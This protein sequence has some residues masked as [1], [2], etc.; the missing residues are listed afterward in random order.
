MRPADDFIFWGS[1]GH[2]KVL[3]DVVRAAGGRIL[4]LF[5][6]D[7]GVH[8]AI[9]GV[10]LFSGEAGF[11]DWLSDH[12]GGMPS[13]A[14]AI[15]GH[16][17]ADRLA[18][19]RMFES[20]GLLIPALVHPQA[21]VSPGARVGDGSQVLAMAVVAAD[22]TLG[23]G[24]IINHGAIVDH[25]SVLGDGCHLAPG[26]VLC[27]CVQLGENVFIGAGATI[28]PR[29]SIGANTIIGA[30]SVVTRDMPPDS[31]AYGTPATISN[32]KL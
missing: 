7:A 19:L 14:V 21:S 13:A 8:P 26:A 22:A 3:A 1:A 11:R 10:P 27:G 5:D 31:I 4:A 15:G 25:E 28:L 24:V 6:N 18:I 32:T 29:L 12:N 9:G 23:R 17:G 2:A 30:G 16:R 20:H